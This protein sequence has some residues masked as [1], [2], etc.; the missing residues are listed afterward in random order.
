MAAREAVVSIVI[1][2]FNR[3]RGAYSSILRSTK[4]LGA[5]MRE[6]FA[7]VG[8]VLGG[9]GAA[10]GGA[11]VVKGLIG[12]NV[13]FQNLK[14]RLQ[15]F[16]GSAEK[17][18]GVFKQL[19]QFAAETPFE[20]QDSVNAFIDL[21]AVGITPTLETLRSMGDVAAAFGGSIVDVSGAIR[22]AIRGDTEMLQKF[23]PTIKVVGDKMEASFN[24]QTEIID[25]TAVAITN[26]LQRLGQSKGV[27]GGAQRQMK[28]LGGAISNLKDNLFQLATTMG[29]GG[30]GDL[31]FNALQRMNDFIK[32]IRESPEKVRF[33][34]QVVI[35]GFKAVGSVLWNAVEIAFR[36]GELIG[37]GLAV[38]FES[39][40]VQWNETLAKMDRAID[41]HP[42]LKFLLRTQAGKGQ[43]PV[44]PATIA[45]PAD[46]TAAGRHPVQPRPQ[47][48][49]GPDTGRNIPA[50]PTPTEKREANAKA[51][52]DA[53]ASYTDVWNHAVAGIKS[54]I[55]DGIVAPVAG[56]M[57]QIRRRP[58]AGGAGA[59]GA[60]GGAG[61]G[62]AEKGAATGIAV[63][64]PV[65][66]T[67]TLRGADALT[68]AINK[69]A[70]AERRLQRILKQGDLTSEQRLDV[71][72]RL[73]GAH[74]EL[75][76]ALRVQIA[77]LAQQEVNLVKA[78]A[79]GDDSVATQ[80]QLV[81]VGARI[82]AML[83]ARLQ[84]QQKIQ[85]INDTLA[86]TTEGVDT[87]G[88]DKVFNAIQTGATAATFHVHSLGEGLDFL[89][90]TG[91]AGFGDAWAEAFGAASEGSDKLGKAMLSSTRKSLSGMASSKAKMTAI[92]AATALAKGLTDPL[93][94]IK[95]ARLFATSAAY[96]TLAGALGGGGGGGGGV[97]GGAAAGGFGGGL[98]TTTDNAAGPE[99]TTGIIYI[100][101]GLVN[102]TDPRQSQAFEDAV[103]RLARAGRIEIRKAEA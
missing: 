23:G 73:K 71:L 101:G 79:A 13:E 22:S 67:P 35:Q 93:E 41:D 76:S 16:T 25:R 11:A 58:T 36:V 70:F 75:S 85:E 28:T 84:V 51:A 29:T 88:I 94:L 31:L 77:L 102:M 17:A 95:A 38:A 45:A 39:V 5:R 68:K 91:I 98:A 37:S 103:N 46:V 4:R 63:R 44:R 96:A 97:G 26:Y 30:V 86:A 2:A 49:I 15:T 92:D 87:A 74:E 100:E 8:G 47:T 65:D 27:A 80:Q 1:R 81:D 59:G 40:V 50:P 54:D 61:A 56:L 34:V 52:R 48:T 9:L 90:G 33:W 83:A 3:T 72:N 12:A 14:V 82:S 20:L 69:D 99:G 53:L 24:G 62:L 43:K 42:L 57:A 10:I 6:T 55:M 7:K 66:L 89:A 78:Q 60:G 32:S 21:R 19:A 64:K 18:A